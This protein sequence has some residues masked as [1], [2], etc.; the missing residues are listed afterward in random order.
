MFFSEEKN[1]TT[2]TPSACTEIVE[3]AGDAAAGKGLAFFFLR[4]T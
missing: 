1:Q 4:R 3:L 2:L